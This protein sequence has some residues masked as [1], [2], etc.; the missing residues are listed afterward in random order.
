M[1]MQKT[2]QTNIIIL[3]KTTKSLTAQITTKASKL[4]YL[5]LKETYLV[6]LEL[7][8]DNLKLTDNKRAF[9]Y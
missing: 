3:I 4:M 5:E 7:I 1:N 9:N 8:L 6:D 2:L